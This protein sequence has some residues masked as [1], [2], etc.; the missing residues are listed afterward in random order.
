MKEDHERR[1]GTQAAQERGEL[2]TV[3]SVGPVSRTDGAK[4]QARDPVPAA[5][6]APRDQ[7][8]AARERAPALTGAQDLVGSSVMTPA[9]CCTG[10]TSACSCRARALR[11]HGVVTGVHFSLRGQVGDAEHGAECSD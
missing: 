3:H 6:T 7:R 2:A 4:E 5:R 9:A 11:V 10:D 1:S 8:V